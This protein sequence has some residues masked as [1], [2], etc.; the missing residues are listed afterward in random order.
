LGASDNVLGDEVAVATNAAFLFRDFGDMIIDWARDSEPP[1]I[2]AGL[3]IDR[4]STA[5]VDLDFVQMMP[6]PNCR[7]ECENVSFSIAAGDTVIVKMDTAWCE[8]ASDGDSQ[9]YRFEWRGE[10]VTLVPNK[11][12][13]LFLLQGEEGVAYD[14]TDAVTNFKVYITPR[15]LL[16][17]GTIA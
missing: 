3:I 7:I 2:S 15:W 1:T 6:F 17:G 14:V 4:D 5:T 13:Y 10:P 8:D 16:P 11:Y 9:L 12:N